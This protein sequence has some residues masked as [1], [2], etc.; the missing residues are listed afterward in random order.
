MSNAHRAY[1]ASIP[2]LSAAGLLV[3]AGCTP[4]PATAT[5][6]YCN[7][8]NPGFEA[9]SAAVIDGVCPFSDGPC[10]SDYV[11][12][13]SR[14]A[15]WAS[16][17]SETQLWEQLEQLRAG[18]AFVETGSIQGPD[19]RDR[20]IEAANLDF[21]LEQLDGGTLEVTELDEADNGPGNQR[22]FLIDD[23]YVG[24]FRG[25]SLKPDGAGP[26]PTLIIAHGHE[27]SDQLWID[28]YDGWDLV[29]RGYALILPTLRVNRA[30]Q[31]ESDV[32]LHLLRGGFTMMAM[33]VYETLLATRYAASLPHVDPCRIGLIGHSGGS[34]ASNITA[35]ISQGFAAYVSDLQ[36]VYYQEAPGDLFIDET[37]PALHALHPQINDFD[38]H[39]R[40]ALA[41]GYRYETEVSPTLSEWPRI[42][43]FLAEHLGGL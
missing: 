22:P 10:A 15:E 43:D 13:H 1:T 38:T 40:P 28:R 14:A 18:T 2:W 6:D 8:E 33:R 25:L 12:L 35:R 27:E 23:P 3:A 11:A 16:P 36:S 7:G 34:V 42:Y 5:L 41:V 21:L 19:L 31:V 9:G 37:S 4:A 30:E 26:F 17:I 39:E 29:D 24:Q 32:T 20:L